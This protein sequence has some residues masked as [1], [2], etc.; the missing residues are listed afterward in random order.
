LTAESADLMAEEYAQAL[1]EVAS[2]Y[3]DQWFK[4]EGV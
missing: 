2:A 1:F 4:W 3:P